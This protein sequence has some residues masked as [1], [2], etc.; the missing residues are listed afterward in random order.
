MRGSSRKERREL[1]VRVEEQLTL[2][3]SYATIDAAVNAYG[4]PY[5][6][7]G[8]VEREFKSGPLLP[9]ERLDRDREY[10]N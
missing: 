8:M 10:P 2:N 9:S 1:R 7:G 4:I 3:S 6:P 5:V